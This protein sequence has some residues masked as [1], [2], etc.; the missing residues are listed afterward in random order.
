[1]SESFVANIQAN[2]VLS[3]IPKQL[4]S[5][6]AQNI[7]LNNLTINE[8]KLVSDIQS[9]LSNHKF[10]LNIEGLNVG[11][12]KKQMQ[13]S[14]AS[15]GS[16]YA[17]AFNN[18]ISSI[19]T[20]TTNATNTIQ[21]MRDTLASMKFDNSSI[22][23]ITKD[24][25]KMNLEVSNVVTKMN[26]DSLNVTIKGVDE[27]GRA[28]TIVKEFDYAAGNITSVG[29]TIS[30]TFQTS[31][32][33]AKQYE[34]EVKKTIIAQE[35]LTKS[36]TLSNKIE[37]YMNQNEKAAQKF[38]D[39]LRELQKQLGNNQSPDFLK[40]ASYEFTKIKSEA[41]A[42]GLT[43][44]MF[45]KEMK[46]AVLQTIGLG[47]SAM[48]FQKVIQMLKLM[49]QQ[50]YN[51]DT[52]MTNLYKVTDESGEKYQR[53]LRQTNK[54]AQ[55]VGKTVSSL[56]EQTATWAKLGYSLDDS[57][58]LAK[59]S[60]VYAN[61]AEV[62]D[63]TAVSDIVT[64]MKAFNIEAKNAI[65][66]IDPLNELGNKFATSAGDLG[67]G[68]SRSASAM[69]LAGT[70][71]YETLAMLTGGAEITQN[72]N[73]FGNMLKIGSMRIRGMKGELEALGEDVDDSINSISKVQTQILN[74]THGKVNIFNENDDFRNYYEIIKEIS[75][76]YD[77]LKST[78]QAALM[79]VLF[80]KQRGNQGAALIQ[81]FQSGQ[82]EKAY[83]TAKNSAGSA[84]A[85]QEK[86]MESLEA[87]TAQFKSSLET[88]S[89]TVLN[90]DLI[91][92]LI[93]GGT[94]FL[95]I[96]SKIVD[97][98]G[99]LP[100]I[101]TTVTA[102]LSAFKNIGRDKMSSLKMN[103]PIVIIVLFRYKQFRYY[104]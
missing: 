88:L 98:F 45:A 35:T 77:S 90:S 100:V 14:G 30:Q 9:A 51:I 91:K 22:D 97:N 74:L 20:T 55:E 73:E 64:V 86:W 37:A 12:I 80:G 10:N 48:V 65:S 81:A 93:D 67:E 23:I 75:E 21:H 76:I 59:I 71:I 95:N 72:A 8:N 39:R 13:Q 19:T 29:K 50:V 85:E 42:A 57:S 38:G 66:I 101:I 7:K 82:I 68:L 84:M 104:G 3:E 28:V 69:K 92:G 78:D 17:K 44:N 27:L 62:D 56:I 4:K 61:V 49:Y 83:E 102:G 24:L 87:K 53:F 52:A 34:A 32:S 15:A 31:T 46:Q 1:M 99:T 33:A 26:G 5:I 16:G 96:V 25:Q 6:E 54:D 2:L 18:N 58:K 103:I 63:N 11:N 41:K 36:Q 79:E 89:N 70:D 60:S 47:S 40:Q 94:D 43:V